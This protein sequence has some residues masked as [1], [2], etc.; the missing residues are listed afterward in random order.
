MIAS[1]WRQCFY[2]SE[3]ENIHLRKTM[4]K[5]QLKISRRDRRVGPKLSNTELNVSEEHKAEVETVFP[6]QQQPKTLE[7]PTNR[8]REGDLSTLQTKEKLSLIIFRMR[9]RWRMTTV[10]RAAYGVRVTWSPGLSLPGWC[11]TPSPLCNRSPPCQHQ[12][13]QHSDI[14][15]LTSEEKILFCLTSDDRCVSQHAVPVKEIMKEEI[16]GRIPLTELRGNS[17]SAELCWS[18]NNL[19][20][21]PC[22]W[23]PGIQTGIKGLKYHPEGSSTPDG[24]HP[25]SLPHHGASDVC[26]TPEKLFSENG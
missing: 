25:S 18:L 26:Q 13:L 4:T 2:V 16:N 19:G 14:P 15:T 23:I 6:S 1:I 22:N 12:T 24:P 17:G 7:K 20:M 11:S 9:R 8:T 3:T 5:L 21:R 10:A